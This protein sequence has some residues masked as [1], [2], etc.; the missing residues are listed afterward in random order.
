M[1]SLVYSSFSAKRDKM[2]VKF[3]YSSAIFV[4]NKFVSSHKE[5]MIDSTFYKLAFMSVDLKLRCAMAK[6]LMDI[7]D[8]DLVLI[9]KIPFLFI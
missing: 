2:L 6:H 4:I 3:E 9:P 1:M 8:L 7:P 5:I